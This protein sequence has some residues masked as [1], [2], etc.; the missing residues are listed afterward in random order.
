MNQNKWTLITQ[1]GI[2]SVAQTCSLSVILTGS[3]D[4]QFLLVDLR[5]VKPSIRPQVLSDFL[6]ALAHEFGAVGHVLKL[7][8]TWI[9][10][11]LACYAKRYYLDGVPVSSGSKLIVR[12]FAGSNDDLE[13]NET[14][15][16]GIIT[17][18]QSLA[19]QDTNPLIGYSFYLTELTISLFKLYQ[20]HMIAT[21]QEKLILLMTVP[22]DLGAVPTGYL[23]QFIV[24]DAHGAWI[25]H[26]FDWH[27]CYQITACLQGILQRKTAK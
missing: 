7:E 21:G 25:P 20:A 17:M 16:A 24:Y 14:A 26:Q 2:M 13:S 1:A 23:F 19:N 27:S 9:S 22:K 11:R 18:G 4:N 8:E 5:N 15:L 6:T 3:G 12:A 10:S